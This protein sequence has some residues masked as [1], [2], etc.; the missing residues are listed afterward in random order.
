[1]LREW[2][3]T[4]RAMREAATEC[5]ALRRDARQAARDARDAATAAREAATAARGHAEHARATGGAGDRPYRA[6]DND[7]E[8]LD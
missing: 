3:R 2:M 5:E 6:I 7:L 4:V 1:M 8:T